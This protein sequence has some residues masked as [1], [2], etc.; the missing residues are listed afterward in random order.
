MEKTGRAELSVSAGF[1]AWDRRR[2]LVLVA[3]CLVNLCIGSLYA[4]SVF[5]SPMSA[6]LTEVNGFDVGSLAIVFSVANAVGPVTM[7]SGGLVNDRLG[8]RW[9]VLGGGVLFGAGMIGAGF[10]TSVAMLV[11]TYGVGCGLA[12]GL[13]Y[14]AVVSNAV[15]FFPDKSGLVGGIVTASYGISSVIV[16]VAANALIGAFDVTW[17]FKILG[18]AMLAVIAIAS[19]AIARCPA[20]YAPQGWS[21]AE[22]ASAG[23]V[24]RDKDWRGM[25]AD[26]VF[27]AMM[28]ML[29]CGAFSGL[30]VTS[31][32]SAI[33]QALTAMTAAEAA[34][35]VSALALANT[36]GRIVSGLASDKLGCVGT[37]R[38]VFAILA[39]AMAALALSG[40]QATPLF[41]AGLMLTGFCFGSV[42]GIYPGFTARQFG[43]A[44]NSVNYG[45]MFVGFALAGV[46][47]PV[48]MNAIYGG[49]GSYVP[50]FLVAAA[51]AIGGIGLTFLYRALADG[52]TPRAPQWSRSR[53]TV[54]P[55]AKAELE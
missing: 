2:W 53:V 49:T 26:P 48:I 38:L 34:L 16:P 1:S 28:A 10:S 39:A 9:V 33:A 40:P 3:S 12:M 35:A 22:S 11:A 13:V 4:W 19:L 21:A 5:A 36:A 14:G 43:A 30:M 29:C 7:I 31:Q 17:A 27:Y 46:L 41:L 47:G 18:A 32:A 55:K 15:K 42:M 44:H 52:K 20:G 37:L 45:I 23:G 54:G 50:A 25:L 8:P 51:L 6:Y 24:P